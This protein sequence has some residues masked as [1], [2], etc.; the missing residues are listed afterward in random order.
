MVRIL[1]LC[2][3]IVLMAPLAHAREVQG[4]HFGMSM[5]EAKKMIEKQDS[6]VVPVEIICSIPLGL[7]FLDGLP[8]F[9]R[10][11]GVKMLKAYG[12]D[13]LFFY[14]DKCMGL[15]KDLQYLDEFIGLK[16]RHP[17]GNFTT[18]KFP[19]ENV[20]ATVFVANQGGNHGFTNRYFDFYLF[21]DAVRREVISN[22]RGSFCWHVK[23][24]SPNLP[25]YPEEYA[26]CV[27]EEKRMDKGLLAEDLEQCKRYCAE[28]PEIFASS[29]CVSYCEEA[30]SRAR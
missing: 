21:D 13:A 12:F 10:D 20:E 11:T 19:G 29:Q 2:L 25:R 30:H 5:R 16:K 4:L 24:T 8:V 3:V 7:D 15:R 1:P 9:T 28:T 17:E 27:R 14:K 22:V 6:N 18:Y 26:R 23:L